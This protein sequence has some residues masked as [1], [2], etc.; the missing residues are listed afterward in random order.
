MQPKTQI[1]DI[2]PSR[3]FDASPS[4]YHIEVNG[5]LQFCEIYSADSLDNANPWSFQ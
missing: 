4:I 2:L 5:N 3:K 1:R